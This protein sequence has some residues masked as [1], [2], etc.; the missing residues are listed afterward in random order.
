MRRRGA[1]HGKGEGVGGE[2]REGEWGESY[3]RG[4]G[5]GGG[6]GLYKRGEGEEERCISWEGEG[7]VGGELRK[8]RGEL[9]KR[10][11]RAT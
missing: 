8:R 7:E 10:G 2:L 5:G 6:G 1:Y 3:V 4:G 11:G 9:R